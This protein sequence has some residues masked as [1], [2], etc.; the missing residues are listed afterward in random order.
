VSKQKTA[1][2]L[3]SYPLHFSIPTNPLALFIPFPSFCRCR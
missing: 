3:L 1:F 2:L